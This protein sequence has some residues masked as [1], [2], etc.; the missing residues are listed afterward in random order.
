MIKYNIKYSKLSINDL[1]RAKQE[2]YIA[3]KDIDVTDNYITGLLDAIDN[4]SERPKVGIP[5]MHK[6]NFTG[7]YF[8]IYKAYYAFYRFEGE[9]ILVDR[10]L[11]G[12]SDYLNELGLK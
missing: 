9:N 11:Y 3:S 8:T 6:D 1:E 2:V 5:L 10:I 12:K 4:L 7:Y